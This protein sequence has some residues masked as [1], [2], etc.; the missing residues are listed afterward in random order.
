MILID[1]NIIADVFGG[2]AVWAVRS[3]ATLR[4]IDKGNAAI[5]PVVYAELAF[6]FQDR[7]PLDAALLRMSIRLIDMGA[8][9]LFG[10]GRAHADYRARGGPRTSILPDFFIG[11]H[12][13]SLGC[14]LLTRDPARF[15]TAFPNLPL[16]HP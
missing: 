6:G 15:K 11:A 3:E 8:D 10:A 16:L 13:T 5:G 2:S 12:A 9:A 14:P 1:T 7:Q 4:A